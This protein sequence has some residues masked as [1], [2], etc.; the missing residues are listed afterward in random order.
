MGWAQ[1]IVRD[2][3]KGLLRGGLCGRNIYKVASMAAQNSEEAAQDPACLTDKVKPI[4]PTDRLS[5]AGSR[6]RSGLIAIIRVI[7]C[8]EMTGY[9][10]HIEK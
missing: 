6:R 2:S 9:R 10:E 1:D 8:L 3:D 5:M 7:I 4:P